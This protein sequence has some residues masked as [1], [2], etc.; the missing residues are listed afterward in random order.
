MLRRGTLFAMKRNGFVSSVHTRS[1]AAMSIQTEPHPR[2][3][4]EGTR[5]AEIL[6]AALAVLGEVGYDRFT[7]DA[8]AQKAKA[9]KAPLYRRWNGKV[10]L[11]IGALQHDHLKHHFTE[12]GPV[13]TGS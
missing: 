6:E 10:Q 3:R 13:D 11:V 2:P 9:S 12:Q 5:E 8:V 4:V 7:M 1:S